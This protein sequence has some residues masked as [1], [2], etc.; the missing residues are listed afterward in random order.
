MWKFLEPIL[1]IC[2]CVGTVLGVCFIIYAINC[3]LVCVRPEMAMEI[4]F[5]KWN[6]CLMSGLPMDSPLALFWDCKNSPSLCE[7]DHKRPCVLALKL[8]EKNGLCC[9]EINR[10]MHKLDVLT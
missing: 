3:V 5:K 7:M 6:K 10:L 2:D 9:V 8:F 1:T 4:G